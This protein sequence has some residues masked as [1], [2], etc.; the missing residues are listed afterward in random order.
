[1]A[2]Q[3]TVDGGSQWMMSQRGSAMA[4]AG[5]PGMGPT[6]VWVPEGVGGRAGAAP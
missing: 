1:M 3:L 6:K 4:L 2:V 5:G